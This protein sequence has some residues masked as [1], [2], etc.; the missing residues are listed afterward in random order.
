MNNEYDCIVGPPMFKLIAY[1]KESKRGSNIH[2]NGHSSDT[3]NVDVWIH[4][5]SI[6]DHADCSDYY[7]G[8]LLYLKLK[9]VGK[10]ESIETNWIKLRK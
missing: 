7:S 3:E 10:I 9:T 1:E 4:G 5:Y 8:L 6:V 2:S